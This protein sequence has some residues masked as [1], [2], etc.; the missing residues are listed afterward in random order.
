[1]QIWHIM[2]AH[3]GTIMN[4]DFPASSTWGQFNYYFF[5]L[6]LYSCSVS[7]IIAFILKTQSL[8]IWY[9]NLTSTFF[10]SLLIMLIYIYYVYDITVR[11]G[12]S[13]QISEGIQTLIV[14]DCIHLTSDQT[15]S[16]VFHQIIFS[17]LNIRNSNVF[18]Y[19]WLES[20][21]SSPPSFVSS[22]KGREEDEIVNHSN[23]ISV[24]IVQKLT[25]ETE[26]W[27][28]YLEYAH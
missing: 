25:R 6:R 24:G 27:L 26:A 12:F 22:S 18:M 16:W 2:H 1:M 8:K 11:L 28:Q 19:A 10:H 7:N 13:S 15:P 9:D 21:E 4:I 20:N 14:S 3:I 5:I 17:S 23:L